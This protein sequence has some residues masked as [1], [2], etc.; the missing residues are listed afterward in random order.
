MDPSLDARGSERSLEVA[1]ADPAE[2]SDDVRDDFD[3][4]TLVERRRH[5]R[6]EGSRGVLTAGQQC[7]HRALPCT[8]NVATVMSHAWSRRCGEYREL[9]GEP[10]VTRARLRPQTKP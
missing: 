9:L 3:D 1:L 8:P 2:R 7:S 10:C 5:G 4:G 6:G